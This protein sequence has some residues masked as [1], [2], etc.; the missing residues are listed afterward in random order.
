MARTHLVT[1]LPVACDAL[2][3]YTADI[4]ITPTPAAP[5][6]C[7]KV[8]AGCLYHDG[9]QGKAIPSSNRSTS[10]PAVSCRFGF[11]RRFDAMIKLNVNGMLR[12][13]DLP[14]DMPL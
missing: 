5:V 9:C 2:R 6:H 14:D 11:Y 7:T 4:P 12:Q 8:L 1:K 3:R 13:L 10:A